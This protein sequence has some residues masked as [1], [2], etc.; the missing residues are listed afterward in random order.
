MKRSYLNQINLHAF[1]KGARFRS[2]NKLFKLIPD[3]FQRR[4]M[5]Y[6]ASTYN[7]FP[8]MKMKNQ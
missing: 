1:Q 8:R 5:I 4:L 6:P 7:I 2:M 3:Y